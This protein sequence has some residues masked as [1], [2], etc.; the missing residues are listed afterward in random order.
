MACKNPTSGTL[1]G[2]EL[3]MRFSDPTE[4][5]Y[6]IFVDGKLRYPKLNDNNYGIYWTGLNIFNGH[7]A[8]LKKNG[9]V[10]DRKGERH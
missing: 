6:E 4:G 10:I 7:T 9:K 3:Y 8:S 2:I 5:P 1:S